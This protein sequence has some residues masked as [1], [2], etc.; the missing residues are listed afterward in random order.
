MLGVMHGSPHSDLGRNVV[1]QPPPE[2]HGGGVEMGRESLVLHWEIV[3]LLFVHLLVDHILLRH[4][5]GAARPLLVD[6][7]RPLC[8][9]HPRLQAPVASS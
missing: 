7:G 9:L 1:A 8:R 4:A 3:L 2:L 5:E 6:F